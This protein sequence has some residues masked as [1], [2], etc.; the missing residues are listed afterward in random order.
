MSKV[1]LKEEIRIKVEILK[2]FTFESQILSPKLKIAEY[3]GQ[4]IVKT[5]FDAL[6]D[7]DGWLL[8]PSDHQALYKIVAKKKH[9]MRILCDFIAGMTD[10]YALEFYGRLKSENPETIF[11]PF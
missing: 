6:K 10:R 1:F 4:E 3:R 7:D 5:I 2:T 11:K 9:R 8:M